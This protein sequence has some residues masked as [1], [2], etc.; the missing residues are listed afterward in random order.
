MARSISRGGV[1]DFEGK[2]VGLRGR[3]SCTLS[4]GWRLRSLASVCLAQ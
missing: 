3:G 2:C 4:L 1:G